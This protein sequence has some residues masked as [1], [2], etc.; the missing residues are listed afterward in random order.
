MKSALKSLVSNSGSKTP[1]TRTNFLKQKEMLLRKKYKNSSKTKICV[2]RNRM[3]K[4]KIGSM[5]ELMKSLYKMNLVTLEESEMLEQC[6]GGVQD[7]LQ[8]VCYKNDRKFDGTSSI[9]TYTPFFSLKEYDYIRSTFNSC[10]PHP[11]VIARWFESV[12]GSP[13]F[14]ENDFIAL[15]NAVMHTPYQIV[16]SLTMDEMAIHNTIDNTSSL[17]VRVTMDT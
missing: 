4:G 16:F 6:H 10:L 11:K 1:G 14:T 13:G 15:R 8:K 17:M 5:M 7:L 2:Q 3:L 9:C 12:D